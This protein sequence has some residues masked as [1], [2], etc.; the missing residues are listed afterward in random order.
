M[1]KNDFSVPVS[2]TLA[3]GLALFAP[4]TANAAVF[5]PLQ[6]E[7]TP[8]SRVATVADFPDA[9]KTTVDLVGTGLSP[10]S[11]GQA[12]LECRSSQTRIRVKLDGMRNPQNLGVWYTTFVVWAVSAE[13][14][15]VNLG[16]L[17]FKNGEKAELDTSTPLRKLGLI[18]TAEPHALVTA[19]GRATVVEMA[20]RKETASR[21]RQIR[22]EYRCES[23]EN[24]PA[25]LSADFFTPL[26]VVGARNALL[27]ARRAGAHQ[28]AE[29]EFQRAERQLTVLEQTW[30]H[31]PDK[32]AT[33]SEIALDTIR[34]AEAARTVSRERAI[35]PGRDV[36]RASGG[37]SEDDSLV[38]ARSRLYTAVSGIFE[39][40][41]V[42]GGVMLTLTDIQPDATRETLSPAAR[43]RLIRLAEC[44][45]SHVGGYQLD[46]ADPAD[47]NGT[48]TSRDNASLSRAET[49]RAILIQAGIPTDR[50]R[51]A[52]EIE[53]TPRSTPA[54]ELAGTGVR[55]E[56]ILLDSDISR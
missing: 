7:N 21:I 18:V 1:K 51:A 6:E 34:F 3:I 56:I 14:Q 28:N 33:F 52:S 9:A 24:S 37:L 4:S 10:R 17:M 45:K 15:T 8:E 36:A 39:T 38:A 27:R 19:P 44:L 31:H 32:I 49:I 25:G 48:G 42:P 43:G 23:E 40:H 26:P 30:I 29:V 41:R 5:T 55:I 20:L 11:R 35:A 22:V 53:S 50:F 2:F 47:S 16:Q 46:I 54:R 13:G 12:E